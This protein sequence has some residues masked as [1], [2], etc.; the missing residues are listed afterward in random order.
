MFE[1]FYNPDKTPILIEDFDSL[2]DPEK[3][4]S[5]VVIYK[6]VQNYPEIRLNIESIK[7]CESKD[8]IIFLMQS[9][10]GR[11]FFKDAYKWFEVISVSA[12]NFMNDLVNLDFSSVDPAVLK[13]ILLNINTNHIVETKTKYD[14]LKID[15]PRNFVLSL[16]LEMNDWDKRDSEEKIKVALSLIMDFSPEKDFIVMK[17]ILKYLLVSD[18]ELI[19]I[20]EKLQEFDEIISLLK[21]SILY[22][23][24]GSLT[25][26]WQNSGSNL[27]K[28]SKYESFFDEGNDKSYWDQLE[29]LG[30][31]S[32]RLLDQTKLKQSI[33]TLEEEIIEN[34]TS[35]ELYYSLINELVGFKQIQNYNLRRKL[36]TLTKLLQFDG[37]FSRLSLELSTN[38]FYSN[39]S[40]ASF[41]QLVTSLDKFAEYES[42]LATHLFV[43]ERISDLNFIKNLFLLIKL[44]ISLNK[45]QP[46]LTKPVDW[47]IFYRDDF[48]PLKI[49]A[50]YVD[51]I[52]RGNTGKKV[53]EV[54]RNEFTKLY[55][56]YQLEF[57]KIVT[58]N[59]S[60]WIKTA[61]INLTSNLVKKYV[62][63][64]MSDMHDHKKI[65]LLFDGLPLE[66][67][68]VLKK[69]FQR[70][71][72]ISNDTFAFSL[73]PS[74]TKF[75]RLAIFSGD[76]PKNIDSTN[77][78]RNLFL[79]LGL[80]TKGSSVCFQ[81]E[82]DQ[83]K[84]K[85]KIETMIRSQYPV[86]SLIFNFFDNL[87]HLSKNFSNKKV[88]ISYFEENILP[89]LVTISKLEK[90]IIFIFSDHGFA[91]LTEEYHIT[92]LNTQGL[93]DRIPLRYIQFNRK[94]DAQ[95]TWPNWSFLLDKPNEWGLKGQYPLLISGKR[96]A[97]TGRKRRSSDK[98][99]IID[100]SGHGGIT[101]EE[102]IVP[103]AVCHPKK[104]NKSQFSPSLDEIQKHVPIQAEKIIPP[105][106]TPT[107]KRSKK[108]LVKRRTDEVFDKILEEE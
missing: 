28:G 62:R 69:Y 61:N 25:F 53:L 35:K 78:A 93:P 54:T 23:T 101:L 4:N 108:L 83:E 12:T 26:D 2:L 58:K 21:I 22:T 42:A 15:E 87:A 73:L 71:F 45:K 43:A 77:E 105:K 68:V 5:K 41:D 51:S 44:Q 1:R 89:I 103:I 38:L 19:Q 29:I 79:Q 67:W 86:I 30:H 6:S 82:A 27:F 13:Y 65:I 40:R 24:L 94:P 63:P 55:D 66:Y 10:H 80:D 92:N 18:P 46:K 99:L 9:E 84:N 104:D 33:S 11:T 72:T 76:L 32:K 49:Q 52:Y 70:L 57:F 98:N 100:K 48:L 97:F 34:P 91:N 81:T 64:A 75:S 96:K 37:G 85:E 39:I 14:S 3:F 8:K 16:I 90:T 56:D 17:S 31:Y 36:E 7:S 107:S 102:M 95:F 106:K 47:G 50:D 88:V 20:I 59:Y 74:T 60:S